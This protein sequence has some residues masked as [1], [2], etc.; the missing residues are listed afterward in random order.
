MKMNLK[1]KMGDVGDILELPQDALR[2][3][4]KIILFGA[5]ALSVENHTGIRFYSDNELTIN[6][7]DGSLTI[8]GKNIS[9]TRFDEQNIF[10][11]GTIISLFLE[12]GG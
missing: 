1:A 10:I 3:I 4:P 5:K 2:D 7:P 12:A 11:E 9:I 8:K 6:T